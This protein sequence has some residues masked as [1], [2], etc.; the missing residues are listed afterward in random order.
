MNWVLLVGG[1]IA[2]TLQHYL[3][4]TN[5]VA[6][7]SYPVIKPPCTVSVVIPAFNEEA[8]IERTLLCVQSQ[9]VIL[10]Y[11]ELFEVIVVDNQSEDGTA[12]IAERYARVVSA[13]RGYV[14]A[15]ARGVEMAEGKIIVFIDADS[16][17]KPNYLNLLLRHFHKMEVVGVVG[18]LHHL[19][20]N[21]I[22]TI[23]TTYINVINSVSRYVFHGGVS[24][25]R[26]DAWIKV[27][28]HD[29]L[30]DQFDRAAVQREVEFQFVKKLKQ[31]GK[32]VVDTEATLWV[33]PRLQFCMSHPEDGIL[34]RNKGR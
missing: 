15:R 24:A 1:F 14:N 29:L 18:S 2:G 30:V 23:G 3:H 9:N 31:V 26:K 21:F 12:K 28:G 13:P 7:G 20:E 11:P 5:A 4:Q 6:N 27:E 25:F 8:F 10:A 32:V 33:E 19:H 16:I 22:G 34:P 17:A